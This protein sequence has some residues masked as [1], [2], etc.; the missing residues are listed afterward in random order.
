MVTLTTK[1]NHSC[2]ERF[3]QRISVGW[4]WRSGPKWI[5]LITS[6]QHWGDILYTES[7]YDS[8]Q[9]L[10]TENTS[11]IIPKWWVFVREIGPLSSGKSC[12]WWNFVGQDRMQMRFAGMALL[13]T[14]LFAI[15]HYC[16]PSKTYGIFLCHHRYG[17][18]VL[19]RWLKMMLSN[20]VETPIFLDADQF[21]TLDTVVPRNNRKSKVVSAHLWEHTPKP[22]AT[23]YKGNPFIVG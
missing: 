12:G 4:G 11:K 16:K 6:Q 17:A 8:G 23:G 13:L 1:R 2:L 7:P 21:E 5:Y 19:T 22:V 14:A 15:Y 3:H 20:S 18:G 10:A 9:I